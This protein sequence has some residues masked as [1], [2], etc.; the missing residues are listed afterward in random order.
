MVPVFR[1]EIE[2]SL[3]GR[4]QRYHKLN[5]AFSSK[6]QGL[7]KTILS[8]MK[9]KFGQEKT[10]YLLK[11]FLDFYN[12]R[13]TRYQAREIEI[14]SKASGVSPGFIT[15]FNYYYEIDSS[16]GCTTVV[17]RTK[18]NE[19]IFGSNLDFDF[20]KDFAGLAYVAEYYKN[21]RHVYTAHSL[22]GLLGYLRGIKP[23]KFSIGLNERDFA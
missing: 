17:S 1:I 6:L 22:Y 3:I 20:P 14:I 16:F 15:L 10:E 21:G 7:E 13:M 23:G 19:I 12:N 11:F 4:Y 18:D 5:Q 8:T 9:E 2:N